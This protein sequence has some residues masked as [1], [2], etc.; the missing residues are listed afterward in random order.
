MN[1]EIILQKEKLKQMK[2]KVD[3][4]KIK[5]DFFL[6]KLFYIMKANRTLTII[7]YNKKLQKRLNLNITDYEKFAQLF[8]S[9]EIKLKL[10]ESEYDENNKFI[11]ISDK[12]KEYFHIYFDNS[13]EEIERNFLKKNEKVNRIKVLINYQV[14]SFKELF[15]NCKCINSIAFINFYRINITDMKSMF[16]GCSSLNEL[17]LSKFN[18]KYV[19]NMSSMFD[20]CSLLEEINLSNFN[21]NNVTNI[22]S[23][24][25]GC[26]SLKEL[27]KK[28]NQTQIFDE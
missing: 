3:L 28:I 20:G 22:S 9:I 23:M 1:S 19:T 7:K 14:K 6:R 5:S 2:S 4:K 26:S 21:T 12:E 16:K 15:Y 8:S 13:N 24:F 27:A 11:N 18:T 10:D 25:N 17:D